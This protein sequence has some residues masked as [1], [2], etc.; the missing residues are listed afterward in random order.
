MCNDYRSRRLQEMDL[1]VFISN[2]LTYAA[3]EIIDLM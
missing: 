2:R 1:Q 3:V